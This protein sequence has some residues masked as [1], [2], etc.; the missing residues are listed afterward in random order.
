MTDVSKIMTK[1]LNKLKVLIIPQT[2]MQGIIMFSREHH[3]WPF[4]R[5]RTHKASRLL[6]TVI[7]FQHSWLAILAHGLGRLTPHAS[8]LDMDLMSFKHQESNRDPP[9]NS[10]VPGSGLLN[11]ISSV[12]W[13]TSVN[14]IKYY[15]T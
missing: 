4:T 14:N 10:K 12:Y 9:W 13:R 2:F 11:K 6:I 5:P 3:P 1:L 7:P 8:S 15:L